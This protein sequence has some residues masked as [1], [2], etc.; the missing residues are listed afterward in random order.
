MLLLH[1]GN[2]LPSAISKH[3]H[4]DPKDK[5]QSEGSEQLLLH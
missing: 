1:G 4:L 2:K 5:Q 3:G